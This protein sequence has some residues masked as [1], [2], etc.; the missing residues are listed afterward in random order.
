MKKIKSMKQVTI[1]ATLT[2]VLTL[3]ISVGAMAQ[4]Q[5]VTSVPDFAAIAREIG[6]DR[7][8][9]IS[10][11]KGYQNPHFVDAK[12]IFV[13][14]LNQADM[15]VY[16]GLEL[17]IGWLPILITGA[18]NS[19]ILGGNA[20]GHYDVSTSIKN[21]LEVPI[22]PVDRSMGDIHPGGNPHYM[23]DPRNGAPV[24]RG[25]AARLIQIDPENAQFYEE[26]FN[27]FISTLKLKISEWNTEL[28]PFKGTEVVTY[29][30][31]WAYFLDWAGFKQAGTIEPKPGIPPTPSHVANLI[32][33]MEAL[34][35]NLIV[36]A[37][38]YPQKTPQI[39]AQKT[40]ATFL[41]LPAMVEGNEGINSY[42]ELFDA[43]VGEI[44]SALKQQTGSI[45]KSMSQDKG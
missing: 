27:N 8:E 17:E 26:N 5:I 28:A 7:V 18:R 2:F 25:I 10:L 20:I 34:D 44:T 40:G 38:Y 22:G 30:K 35:V 33:R 21:R 14:K 19:D 43:I 37:N 24:A 45:S 12:P 23:L 39:I 16:N 15:M 3:L 13:T 41:V 4:V 6:G 36:A 9:V 29:H 32:K 1:T 11:A 42:F 31:L